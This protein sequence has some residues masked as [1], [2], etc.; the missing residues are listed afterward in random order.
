LFGDAIWHNYSHQSIGDL[1]TFSEDIEG[2]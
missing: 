1:F 2:S